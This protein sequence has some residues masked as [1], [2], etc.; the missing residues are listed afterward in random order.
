MDWFAAYMRLNPSNSGM[1][2]IDYIRDITKNH[3]ESGL[4]HSFNSEI[5]GKFAPFTLVE[6]VVLNKMLTQW[7]FDKKITEK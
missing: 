5:N 4:K 7:D 1:T 3:E 6:G 2:P